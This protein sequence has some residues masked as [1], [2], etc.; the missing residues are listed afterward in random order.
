MCLKPDGAQS[1]C[2]VTLDYKFALA[3]QRLDPPV[4]NRLVPTRRYPVGLRLLLVIY[5]I[6]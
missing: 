5:L 3:L 2:S 1:K 4:Y 6:K